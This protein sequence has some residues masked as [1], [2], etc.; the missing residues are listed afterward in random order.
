MEVVQNL[1]CIFRVVDQY[2]LVICMV[3]CDYYVVCYGEQFLRYV[4]LVYVY[5]IFFC[6]YEFN[7]IVY[8]VEN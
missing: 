6:V 3:V 4:V 5:V 1:D 8:C 2:F 7:L